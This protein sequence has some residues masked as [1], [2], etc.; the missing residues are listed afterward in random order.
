M[1]IT[2]NVCASRPDDRNTAPDTRLRYDV[3]VT[4]DLL[5][6]HGVLLDQLI[7]FGFE[8]LDAHVLCV[9]IVPTDDQEG[10]PSAVT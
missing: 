3:E 5:D 8:T 6:E 4:S 7:G 1:A 9:R 2:I 10:A